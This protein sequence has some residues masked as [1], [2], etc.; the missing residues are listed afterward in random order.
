MRKKYETNCN[1]LYLLADRNG[2]TSGITQP[3]IAG[4]EEVIRK[5]YRKARLHA[6]DTVYVECHGTGTKVGDP[7]EVEALSNTFSR[8]RPSP[9]LLGAVR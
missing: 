5:A 9:L 1:G 4:Q 2:K 3:S 8:N 7:M 6:E